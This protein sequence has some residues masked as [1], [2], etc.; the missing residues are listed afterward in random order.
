M[1]C[2]WNIL[3]FNTFFVFF[4]VSAI[5]YFLKTRQVSDLAP[6]LCN[7]NFRNSFYIA[8]RSCP[9]PGQ[10][11][12]QPLFKKKI[13]NHSQNQLGWHWEW[14]SILLCNFWDFITC[15]NQFR[16]IFNYSFSGIT[17]PILPLCT[18]PTHSGQDIPRNIPL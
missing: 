10:H 12:T 11:R 8:V 4:F 13:D 16:H 18:V 14:L 7:T 9:V 3:F 5:V 6:R 2:I 1:Y 17:C 15:K